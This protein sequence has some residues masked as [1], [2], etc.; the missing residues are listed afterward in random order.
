M[1]VIVKSCVFVGHI[2]RHLW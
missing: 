2:G 1:A